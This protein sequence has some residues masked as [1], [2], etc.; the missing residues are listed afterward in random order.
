MTDRVV[1]HEAWMRL[2]LE[3]AARGAEEG[4]VPVGAVLLDEKGSLLAKDHNRPIGRCDPTAHAEILVLREGARRVANYRLAGT[5]LYVTLEPCA[6]CVGAM[7]HARVA[8]L[9]FGARDPKSGA[10][11]SVVDLTRVS[12]FNHT[13][14]VVGGVESISC[15]QLIQGFFRR[16]RFKR[17]GAWGE[18]PKWP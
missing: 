18:V 15:A 2:A 8:T 13:I 16:R 12:S 9:V 14:K 3:E 6:M 7:L 17:D 10:A 4:E 5:V 1:G 11:G